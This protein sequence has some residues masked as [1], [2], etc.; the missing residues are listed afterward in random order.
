MN[1]VNL[2]NNKNFLEG[3]RLFEEDRKIPAEFV[4]ETLKEAIVKTYQNHVDAPAA[5]VRVEIDSKGIQAYHELLVVDDDSDTF[6]DTLDILYSEAVKIK[7]DVKVGDVIEEEINFGAISRTSINVAKQM[8]KQNTKEFDK[9][10]VYD[11]YK[12]KE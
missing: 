12:D 5:K 3:M 2:K 7:P 9:Q 4:I 11:E 10:R 1:G 6:D 8:L